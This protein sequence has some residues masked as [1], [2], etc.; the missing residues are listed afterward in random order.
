M[1]CE[2]SAGNAAME[3]LSSGETGL[4]LHLHLKL[5]KYHRKKKKL[6]GLLNL[7]KP[8]THS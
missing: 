5:N 7:P 3:I 6:Q 4:S 8:S 2:D 1:H